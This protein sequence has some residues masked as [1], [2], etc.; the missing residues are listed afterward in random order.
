MTPKPHALDLPEVVYR[1]VWYLKAKDVV[2]C[3]LVRKSFYR[4]FGPYT[5]GNIHLGF[6]PNPQL[7]IIRDQEPLA[8]FISCNTHI[9]KTLAYQGYHDDRF[10]RF[11]RKIGPWIRSLSVHSHIFMRDLTFDRHCIM[12][13]SLS[14]EGPP[15]DS[16]VDKLYWDRCK[17]LVRQNSARL[18]SLTLVNWEKSVTKPLPHQP[19]WSPLLNF[20][21]HMNLRSL[22]VKAGKIRGRHM[23]AFWKISMRLESLELEA[24]H[25]DLPNPS[26]KSLKKNNNNN[27]DNNPVSDN[28]G[29]HLGNITTNDNDINPTMIDTNDS[30]STLKTPVLRFPKLR[31]LTLTNLQHLKPSHQLKQLICHCPMLQTLVWNLKRNM[32]CPGKEFSESFAAMTWPDLDWIVIKDQGGYISDQECKT[33]LQAAKQPFRRLDLRLY[34]LGKQAFDMMLQGHSRTLT[35]VDLCQ[36]REEVMGQHY[37]VQGGVSEWVQKILESCPLLEHIS[38]RTITADDILE[39]EPWVC[40][41]LQMFN[42]MINM[43]FEDVRLKRGRT[44][45]MFTEKEER[46]CYEIYKRLTRLKHLRVLDMRPQYKF[47]LCVQKF[48]ALPLQVGMG[49]RQL[50]KLKDIEVIGYTGLQDMRQV[51]VEWMLRH[52]PRIRVVTGDRLSVKPSKSFGN[53]FVRDYLL[54]KVLKSGGVQ[55]PRLKAVSDEKLK[56]FMKDE[57]IISLYDSESEGESD[58]YG[59][60]DID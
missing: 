14:I 19:I 28:N 27:E 43:E 31:K 26:N 30:S 46:Q 56:Q 48:V 53:N 44:R 15:F 57:D 9:S 38:G 32:P 41:G 1:V 49:L 6:L 50:S 37:R 22:S 54:T 3:S 5:W 60:S 7:N 10:L 33:I 17:A 29:E 59:D 21:H 4:S 2:A 25:F 11:I 34:H 36:G 52:W 42:V 20:T 8:R 18:R 16:Q 12:L 47:Q 23:A 35:K 45:L 51:D 58:D 13:E 40:L 24:V 55:A 39:G